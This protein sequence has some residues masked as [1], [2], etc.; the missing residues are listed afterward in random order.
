VKAGNLPK[1]ISGAVKAIKAFELAIRRF[2]E[3]AGDLQKLGH[4]LL[5]ARQRGFK[6]KTPT[7]TTLAS[8]RETTQR[9][10]RCR[11]C[12]SA[13]HKTPAHFKRGDV[14]YYTP[15]GVGT[16]ALGTTTGMAAAKLTVEER[17]AMRKAAEEDRQAQQD[18][19]RTA[20]AEEN[21]HEEP[22]GHE[23]P[24]TDDDDL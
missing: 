3:V 4:K 5:R 8:K 18:A 24:E 17:E 14:T 10:R 21:E 7:K 22:P 16:I 19:D 13:T 23:P 12:R 6:R 1:T 11:I 15:I 20:A 9:D 2:V